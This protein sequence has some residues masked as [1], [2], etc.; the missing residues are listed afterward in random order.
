[1]PPS[2]SVVTAAVIDD[3]RA[4]PAAVPAAEPPAAAATTH[5]CSHSDPGA[6][7][8]DARSS[9]A[10]RGIHR[11]YIAGNNIRSAVNHRRIVLRNVHNLWVGGLNDNSLRR[12]LHDRDL[13]TGLEG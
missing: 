4:V 8:N 10:A 7:A 11:S 6:E 13:R 3:S 5:Q 9:H 1:M 12:L 2:V